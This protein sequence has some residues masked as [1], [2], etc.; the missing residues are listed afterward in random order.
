MHHFRHY[1]RQRE[2]RS[3]GGGCDVIGLFEH[4]FAVSG[5]E[6]AELVDCALYPGLFGS[7][8]C[9]ARQ[10]V[11]ADQTDTF[12]LCGVAVFEVETAVLQDEVEVFWDLREIAFEVKRKLRRERMTRRN[13]SQTGCCFEVRRE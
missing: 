3:T 6:R 11:R 4:E 12:H 1:V 9:A 8:F 13:Y 5:H 2:L 10:E 7:L